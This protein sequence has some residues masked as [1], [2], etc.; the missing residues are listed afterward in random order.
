[1]KVIYVR[2]L[3]KKFRDGSVNPRAFPRMTSEDI[4]S[5][6]IQVKGVGVWT[7]HMLLIFTL[8]RLDILPTGDLGIRKGFQIVY[9][10]RSL[11]SHTHM[12]RLARPWREH[13]SVASWYLW[14]VADSLKATRKPSPKKSRLPAR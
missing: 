14:R 1:M 7:A 2:D 12:E 8:E 11:P 13:A 9:K 5:H 3:A 6:L 4:I 10:L